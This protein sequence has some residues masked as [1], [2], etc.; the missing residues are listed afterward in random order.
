MLSV[1]DASKIQSVYCW[2]RQEAA[3]VFN[4]H[5]TFQTRCFQLKKSASKHRALS[6]GS[7]GILRWFCT[8]KN[9]VLREPAWPNVSHASEYHYEC[10]LFSCK[11]DWGPSG[12]VGSSRSTTLLLCWQCCLVRTS[13]RN[14]KLPEEPFCEGRIQRRIHKSNSIIPFCW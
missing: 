7:T 2:R 4:E 13:E 11:K 10:L 12:R 14:S 5:S 1:C 8:S 9:K 6:V 3:S